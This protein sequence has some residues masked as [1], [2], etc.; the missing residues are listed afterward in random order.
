MSDERLRELYA[1]AVAAGRTAAGQK[2]VSPEAIA[3][4]VRREGSERDRLATLDHVMSCGDCRREYDL[5][6]TVERAGAEAEAE[7]RSGGQGLRRSLVMPAALAASLLLAVGVG[8][9]LMRSGGDD[10]TRGGDAGAIALLRPGSEAAVGDSIVFAWHPVAGARRYELEL[11][12]PSGNV[13]AA[14][15]TTDT[16]AAP[17]AARQLPA[18]DYRWW[19]RATTSDARTV[20]S[21][22][23]PLHLTPK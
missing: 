17:A 21:P 4:L 16:I 3:A 23:R 6:R 10:T 2:H 7:G 14:A 11:I 22:L 18:G 20:R 1:G 12:D 15:E 8:R 5:L 9:T 13:V 19:V